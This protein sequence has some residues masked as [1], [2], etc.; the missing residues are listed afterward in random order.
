MYI[1]EKIGLGLEKV[2]LGFEIVLYEF[3][4][5]VDSLSDRQNRALEFLTIIAMI[6]MF[7]FLMS[8]TS[9]DIDEDHRQILE[10]MSKFKFD[11]NGK[12]IIE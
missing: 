2:G 11:E 9:A 6:S 3:G 4:K 8:P 12:R 5:W 7:L 1:L 10:K